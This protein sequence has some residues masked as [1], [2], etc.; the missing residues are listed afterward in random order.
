MLPVKLYFKFYLFAWE[1]SSLVIERLTR[2]QG[3][4]GS[5]L[6]DVTVLCP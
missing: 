2:D 1:P 4:V 6:T 3:A 5:S